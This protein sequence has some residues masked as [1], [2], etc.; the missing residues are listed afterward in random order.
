MA[1]ENATAGTV[2]NQIIGADNNTGA[3]QQFRL[4]AMFFT[5][6]AFGRNKDYAFPEGA[7]VSA[8][9]A[10]HATS[11]AKLMTRTYV[12]PDGNEYDAWDMLVACTKYVLSQNV[13]LMDNDVNSVNYKKPAA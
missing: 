5:A 10:D 11:L 6:H 13:H 12:M 7:N 3:A 9:M 4:S 1:N 8:S 2:F